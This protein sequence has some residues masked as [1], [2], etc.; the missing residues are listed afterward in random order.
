MQLLSFVSMR[1]DS[2]G[3]TPGKSSAR[4]DEGSSIRSTFSNVMGSGSASADI[5]PLLARQLF[6]ALATCAMQF[7]GYIHII[8]ENQVSKPANLH[9]KT[10][11][12]HLKP[13]T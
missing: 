3:V 1:L 5:S 11:V 10:L 12:S 6:E 2:P 7:R 8:R 4:P 13:E 9:S